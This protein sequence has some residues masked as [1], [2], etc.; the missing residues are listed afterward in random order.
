MLSNDGPG[1]T[2]S[3]TPH[4]A[5]VAAGPPEAFG[6]GTWEIP[7]YAERMAVRKEV[8]VAEELEIAK[9]AVQETERVTDTVRR[10]VVNVEEVGDV[11]VQG[12]GG[13]NPAGGS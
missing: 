5:G 2:R 6:E 13:M 11:D 3:V 8:R 4:W 7:V 9:R 10:E 1:R 12:D